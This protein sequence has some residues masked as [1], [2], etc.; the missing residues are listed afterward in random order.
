MESIADRCG[1]DIWEI[2]RLSQLNAR[3]IEELFERKE[4]MGP[5]GIQPTEPALADAAEE[6]SE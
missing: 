6:F 1:K 4:P 3:K 5:L 2:E